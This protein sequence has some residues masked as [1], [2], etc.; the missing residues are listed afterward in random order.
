MEQNAKYLN[1]SFYIWPT[2]SIGG[3]YGMTKYYPNEI[4][5]G[6]NIPMG[7][8][9]DFSKISGDDQWQQTWQVRLAATYRWSA[10]IPVE[11]THA[12]A[13]EQKFKVKE[14]A[15]E[16]NKIKRAISISISSNYSR[17]KT[18]CLSLKSQKDNVALAEE[19]LRIARESYRAGV[20]KNT[21]L[22]AAELALTNA[23]T[24]YIH[25]VNTY[26]VSLAELKKELGLD[27]DNIIMEDH[28]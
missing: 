18:A 8:Q 14:A 25:S 10:L 7:P 13:R 9:P 5:T 19:G 26:Y 20:I 12:A 2:F 15:E 6:I 23:K 27:D 16:L 24:A 28:K 21:D 1:E 11:P 3:Y 22:L 4:D 17:L